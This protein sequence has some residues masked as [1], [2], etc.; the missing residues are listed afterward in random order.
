MATDSG[1]VD[2]LFETAAPVMFSAMK[3]KLGLT[4][5]WKAWK[6]Q[7][8]AVKANSTLVCVSK[9]GET[10]NKNTFKLDKVTVSEMTNNLATEMERENGIVVH[11]QTI[12]DYD[13]TF[14][15]ILSE[16]ELASFKEALRMVAKEHNIDEGNRSSITKEVK[17]KASKKAVTNQ[18][19]MRR[20]VARAMDKY[21]KRNVKERIMAR[22][23]AMK[24][25]PVLFTSDLVHGSW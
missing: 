18:S 2:T 1:K 4:Y 9:K 16:S 14:R 24:S 15:L 7:V 17:V 3:E 19:V 12:D 13:T 22:R 11:C 25:L 6:Q 21:D 8:V 23:G 20:A 10:S 5:Q